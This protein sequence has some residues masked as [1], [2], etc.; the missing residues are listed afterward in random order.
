M[1]LAKIMLM[2]SMLLVPTMAMGIAQQEQDPVTG[3]QLQQDQHSEQMQHQQ[4]AQGGNIVG[5]IVEVRDARFSVRTDDQ[6]VVWFLITPELDHQAA[7]E[8]VTGNRVRVSSTEGDSPEMREA[9][10]ITRATQFDTSEERDQL[11][12]TASSLPAIGALGLLALVGAAV[13]A[14]ARRF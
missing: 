3:Q 9:T 10:S 12:R 2:S 11:P 6:G 13:V 1:K 5:V 14:I 8:L 4:M 7:S